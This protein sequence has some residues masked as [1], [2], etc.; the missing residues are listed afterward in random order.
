MAMQQPSPG[1]NQLA[2][3]FC[4]EWGQATLV[5]ML[6]LMLVLCSCS[7]RALLQGKASST[8]SFLSARARPQLRTRSITP[9]LPTAAPSS[10]TIVFLPPLKIFQ[11]RTRFWQI[12]NSG[13]NTWQQIK[14]RVS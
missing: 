7:A 11:T 14:A 8:G 1:A 3:P 9:C 4:G 12:G 10:C 2:Q 5:L 13:S 6:V